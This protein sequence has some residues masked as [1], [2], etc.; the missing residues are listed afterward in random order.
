MAYAD[1]N[2]AEDVRNLLKRRK[3]SIRAAAAEIGIPYRSMQNYLSGESRMPATV[4]I[5][6]LDVYAGGDLRFLRNGDHLLRHGDLFDAV[7]AVLGGGLLSKYVSAPADAKAFLEFEEDP[8]F[9][10]RCIGAASE[11]AVRISEEYSNFWEKRRYSGVFPTIKELRELRQ[12]R[13][14]HVGG[15]TASDAEEKP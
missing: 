13:A 6:I 11:I 2:L 15:T 9:R 12:Q 8:E 14:A 5:S 3:V 10:H 4:L 7:I 1:E